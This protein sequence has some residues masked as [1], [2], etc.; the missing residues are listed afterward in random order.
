MPLF[1][2]ECRACK[3]RYEA[4]SRFGE[5]LPACP[6][7]NSEDVEKVPAIGTLRTVVP[8]GY[9]WENPRFRGVDKTVK[10]LPK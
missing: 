6:A 3:N 2:F 7:C 4:M 10:K 8:D 9:K 5:K 1:D